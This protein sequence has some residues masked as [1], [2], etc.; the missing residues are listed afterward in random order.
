LEVK[1]LYS[2]RH[3]KNYENKK[4]MNILITGGCGFLGSNLSAYFLSKDFN[5][6][7]IDD[8]SRH[9]SSSNLEWL[10]KDFN[11]EFMQFD[12]ANRDLIELTIKEFM[13]DALIHLAGQVAMTTSIQNP[14]R[15]FEVNTVGTINLLEAVRKYC[16]K[17]KFIYSSTNKV[18]GD[19]D[20]FTY[21]QTES[22]YSCYE[23]PEGF[24]ESVPLNFTTPY[25]C[26]K[27][28]ADQYTLDYSKIYGLNTAVF[29]HSS[30]YGGRQFSSLDQGWIGWFCMQGI[31]TSKN[32]SNK[33]TISGNGKQVRDILFISDVIDLYSKAISDFDT[34]NG[35][36]F[37][38]GGGL[39]NSLSII[40]LMNILEDKLSVK[41]NYENIDS[42]ISDQKV[43]ISKNAQIENLLNWRP[44]IDIKDGLDQIILW[45]LNG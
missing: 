8:L 35:R 44:K 7:I 6:L 36:A 21:N 43:F 38:V 24:D 25:G 28:A 3:N 10:K 42:R 30:M 2:G 45:H 14:K 27:G 4:N 5:L 33:F 29:R 1:S 32:I 22:R 37:N 11:F 31:H 40:E 9:G 19:L 41:L 20:Q 23:F 18:Y 13:P 17:A 26:S 15:D 34:I 39:K 16:P 12:I